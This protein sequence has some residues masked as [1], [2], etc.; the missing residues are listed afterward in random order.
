MRPNI[1]LVW[2]LAD[3]IRESI[4]RGEM[5]WWKT[6]NYCYFVRSTSREALILRVYMPVYFY[7]P[8]E[9][10]KF[11]W[12]KLPW[13]TLGNPVFLRVQ[14]PEN[15]DLSELMRVIEI[16]ENTWREAPEFFKY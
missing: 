6:Q 5:Q 13:Y 9:I 3:K 14:L 11:P 2:A 15:P 12:D 10:E 8:W 4:W 7:I 16:I 1:T